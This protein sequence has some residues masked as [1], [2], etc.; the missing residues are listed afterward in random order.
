MNYNYYAWQVGGALPYFTGARVQRGHGFGSLSSGLLRTVAPLIRR[1]AVALE[2]RALTT[3][4]QIAGD[5]VAGK[6]VKK[7]TKRRSMPT[8]ILPTHT[9][10]FELRWFEES[11][12][13]SPPIHRW[14]H[15]LFSQ[16]DVYLND[17]LMTPSS[18]TYPF[19][20]YVDTVLSYGAEA[21]NTQLTSQLLYKDTTGHMDATIVDG[22]NTG[23]VERRRYIAE[24]RIVEMMG[25]LHVDLFLQD[26]FLLNGVSVNIRLVRSKDAFSLMAG[27]Q[28]PDCNV[29]IVNAVL[30][31]RKAVLSPTVQMVHIQ[32]V[33]KGQPSIR[34][35]P[36]R[37]AMST[38]FHKEVPCR[39][40]TK[41]CS[42]GRCR[43]D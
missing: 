23:L 27:G 31:V 16:V 24:S 9:S 41:T 7:A 6:N 30:F 14:H 5:V 28:N 32:A 10:S 15:S 22:G 18:N 26:R 11:T 8:S 2:K 21:K 38:P 4:A 29:Q 1:G 43:N 34:Y 42:L 25:R 17:T 35:A 3:G 13:T 20:A 12:P 40:R 36:W 39:T 37:T 33:E 19:R